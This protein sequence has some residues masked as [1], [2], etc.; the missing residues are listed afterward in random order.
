MLLH[1]ANGE[2]ELRGDGG[3]R[4]PLGHEPEHL[5]LARREDVER[6]A[7]AAREELG[8]HLRVE[9]GAAGGDAAHGADEVVDVHDPVLEQVA[10]PTAAVGEELGRVRVLDVLRDDE[11]RSL[12]CSAAQLESGAQALVAEAGRQA[13]VDDRDVRPLEAHGMP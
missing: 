3:V 6:A 4:T 12:G 5:E 8:D 10:E 13:D 1:R 7:C 2:H 9:R 11:D